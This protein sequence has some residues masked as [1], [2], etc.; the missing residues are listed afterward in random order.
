MQP[1]RT[2]RMSVRPPELIQ[3]QPPPSRRTMLSVQEPQNAT[4]GQQVPTQ[5]RPVQQMTRRMYAIPQCEAEATNIVEEGKKV[6][7]DYKSNILLILTHSIIASHSFTFPK[8]DRTTT[9]C[10]SDHIFDR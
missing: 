7:I 5:Q 1:Q 2:A 6:I 10:F 8:V 4:Q 9:G 3:F